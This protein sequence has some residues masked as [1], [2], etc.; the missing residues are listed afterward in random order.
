[1]NSAEQPIYILNQ[2]KPRAIIPKILSLLVLS[3]IFY[4]GL[5][6]N[7][8]LVNIAESTETTIKTV[9]VLV[10]LVIVIL[11]IIMAVMKAAKPYLFYNNRIS[12]NNK[13]LYYNAITN[14]IP[15]KNFV[16]T[17]F[18]TYSITAGEKFQLQ[19]IPDQLNLQNYLQQ[20][21]T[22]NRQ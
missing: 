15:Q 8:S 9:S 18:K 3:I 10:L 22:Y 16:D 12:W 2:H 19:H 20:L 11:G 14:T 21:I 4:S 7:L 17:I 6:L 1:M 13:E 5:V